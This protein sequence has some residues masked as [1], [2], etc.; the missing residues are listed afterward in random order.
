MAET[1]INATQTGFVA[2]KNI[3]IEPVT[4]GGFDENT[5]ACWHFDTNAIDAVNGTNTISG[6]NSFS[7]TEGTYRFTKSALLSFPPY[8]TYNN[9]T[10]S[11]NISLGKTFTI[12]CWLYLPEDTSIWFYQ[13]SGTRISVDSSGRIQV[14]QA[15]IYDM[16][17]ALA[18]SSDTSD[19]LF[20]FAF[21]ADNGV[22]KTFVN[23]TDVSIADYDISSWWNGLN[24]VSLYPYKTTTY[25]RNVYIDELRLSNNVRWTSNFAN[26]LPSA[27][28]GG[29]ITPTGQTAINCSLDIS[30]KQDVSNLVTSL[31]NAST[32]TQYPSAKCVYDIVGDIETTLQ[33][34]RGV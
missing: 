32:N 16:L 25:D 14:A 7:D 30:G 15:G 31:S 5:I 29:N 1:K 33:T 8:Q 18:N 2:G 26:D 6:I 22:T 9:Y 20:H 24:L 12:D 17:V 13:E 10:L 21:T 19:K 27:P 11:S 3:T 28:Y 34:I 23:G 4:E